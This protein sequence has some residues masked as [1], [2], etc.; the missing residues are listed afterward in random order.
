VTD[1]AA[2]AKALHARLGTWQ[3]V[4]DACNN[5]R[6]YSRTT[7]WRIAQG[8]LPASPAIAEAI[9]RVAA[10]VTHVTS[11]RTRDERKTV[12]CCCDTFERLAAA[13]SARGDVTWDALLDEAARLLESQSVTP[14]I[15]ERE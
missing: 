8:T 14:A 5:G 10:E 15:T 6:A 13:K 7:Y 4:A 3:A 11:P 12:H 9:S 1:Y 2:L